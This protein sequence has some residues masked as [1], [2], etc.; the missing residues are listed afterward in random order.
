MKTRRRNWAGW[1]WVLGAACGTA[2][3]L[4]ADR[5]GADPAPAAPILAPG[6]AGE[7][8]ATAS[9]GGGLVQFSFEQADI[10]LVTQIVGKITGKKFVVPEGVAVERQS[11]WR[12]DELLHVF[13]LP[14]H[15]NVRYT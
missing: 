1:A 7:D 15:Q 11:L 3:A 5:G 14:Q 8:A 12:I 4:A 10:R 6:F 9:A 2:A 13:F